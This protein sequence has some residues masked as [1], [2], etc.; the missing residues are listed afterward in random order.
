MA[1]SPLIPAIA[2]PT[3]SSAPAVAPAVAVPNKIVATLTSRK[4]WAAL[5]ATAGY[6]FAHTG[7][8]TGPEVQ[9]LFTPILIWLVAEAG[10]DVARILSM[11]LPKAI[12]PLVEP[13]LLAL[14]PKLESMVADLVAKAL[15]ATP[16]PSA[17]AAGPSSATTPT[18]VET[19]AVPSEKTTTTLPDGRVVVGVKP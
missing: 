13:I 14:L 9:T 17:I 5:V 15:T 19:P 7:A 6:F 18:P 10:L 8:W 11:A 3:S 16:Q 2:P 4:F 1:S 12:E